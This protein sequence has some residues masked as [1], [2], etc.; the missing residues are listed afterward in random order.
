MLTDPKGALP[1]YDAVI[2]VSPKRAGDRRLLAAL[3]PMLGAVPVERMR[4]ANLMVDRDADK[5]S[6]REAA[7]WLKR[8]TGLDQAR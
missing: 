4:Q 5:N 8:E 1:A 3:K 6:P 2:L 7:A